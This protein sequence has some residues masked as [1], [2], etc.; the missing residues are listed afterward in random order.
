MI[1]YAFDEVKSKKTEDLTFEDCSTGSDALIKLFLHELKKIARRGFY[2]NYQ[3]QDAES[4]LVKGKVDVEES[5]KLPNP[6]LAI[7]YDEFTMNNGLNQVLKRTLFNLRQKGLQS[8]WQPLVKRLY[9]N[10]DTVDLKEAVSYKHTL[11]TLNNHY[12]LALSLAFFINNQIIPKDEQGDERFIDITQNEETMHRIYERFLRN[13]YHIHTN[14]HVGS[15]K[16]DWKL[17]PLE[18]R[19][20]TL[21]PK[22]ETDIEIKKSSDEKIIIDA[23][24]YKEALTSRYETKKLVSSNLYQMYTYLDHN[25]HYPKLRGILL[26]PFNGHELNHRFR[27]DK[28]YDMEAMTVNLNRPWH[29]IESRLLEIIA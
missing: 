5:L 12:R 25:R 13:F 20:K 29:E 6:N 7:S 4:T 27:S 9:V 23:K 15:H 28:N 11:T 21:L 3:T 18:D 17:Y 14:Y 26:Y 24:Y 22:M 1:L 2:K 16:Y 19:D 8:A 10:F